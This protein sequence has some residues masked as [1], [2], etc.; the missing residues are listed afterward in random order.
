MSQIEV[1][2]IE[3]KSERLNSDS[4]LEAQN[5]TQKQSLQTPEP[6]KAYN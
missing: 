5:L 3:T 4:L 2:D 6:E 1:K